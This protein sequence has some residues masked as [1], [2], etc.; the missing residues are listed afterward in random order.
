[1]RVIITK[2]IKL[3]PFKKLYLYKQFSLRLDI[4]T[5]LFSILKK[6]QKKKKRET[7]IDNTIALKTDQFVL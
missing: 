3:K 5:L 7:F 6:L 2:N 4:K 1:M